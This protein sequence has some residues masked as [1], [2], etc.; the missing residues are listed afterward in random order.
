MKDSKE[1]SELCEAWLK[2]H[3]LNPDNYNVEAKSVKTT[4]GDAIFYFV[5]N[6]A[7]AKPFVNDAPIADL[8]YN[9]EF[10]FKKDYGES[11]VIETDS[12]GK[13]A[14]RHGWATRITAELIEGKLDKAELTALDAAF[15]RMRNDLKY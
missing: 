13:L 6:K 5:Y 1:F 15:D 8:L 7:F 14:G 2:T 4:H 10:A 12:R 9:S 3:K 11:I